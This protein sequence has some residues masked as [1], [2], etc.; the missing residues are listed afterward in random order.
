MKT[1]EETI[2]YKLNIVPY[3]FIE[4][5][6]LNFEEANELFIE[7]KKWIWLLAI[8]NIN[9]EKD[10]NVPTP[11]FIDSS[12]I[13]IDEMWHTFILFT[14]EY[15]KFCM[16]CF[17]FFIHHYPTTKYEKDQ[18]KQELTN[19]RE[20]KI[21]EVTGNTKNQYSYI[22]DRLGKETLIKWY[23][24]YPIKYSPPNIKKLQS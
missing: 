4:N 10:K 2:N 3:K 24:E 23:H 14:Y 19:N 1:L 21:K 12:M 15:E 20:L 18:F 13:F 22:Y 9:R 5:Y 7:T 16:E 17:G 11:L 8:S 6:N